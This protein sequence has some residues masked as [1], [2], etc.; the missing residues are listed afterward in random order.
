MSGRTSF[1]RYIRGKR[2]PEILDR[3]APF[4]KQRKRATAGINENAMPAM[5][6]PVLLHSDHSL[7]AKK[8][9]E[10]TIKKWA[11]ARHNIPMFI[12]RML[13][14]KKNP[15]SKCGRTNSPSCSESFME[16]SLSTRT[17]I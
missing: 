6:T 15:E 11:R 3:L 17:S 5:F 12:V 16:N 2:N 14:K 10:G 9:M 7:L 4:I 13:T 8:D 1:I